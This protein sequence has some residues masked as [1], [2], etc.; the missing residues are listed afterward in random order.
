M[1]H[2]ITTHSINNPNYIKM[3]QFRPQTGWGTGKAARKASSDWFGHARCRVI[4]QVFV[5]HFGFGNDVPGDEFVGYL[6][7]LSGD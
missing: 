7:L 2:F 5:D 1:P 6:S 4:R 3:Q